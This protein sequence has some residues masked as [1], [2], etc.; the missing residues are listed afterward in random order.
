MTRPTEH[1]GASARGQFERKSLEAFAAAEEARAAHEAYHALWV[2]FTG[3]KI[4]GFTI[5]FCTTCGRE[6]TDLATC[7]HRA[8]PKGGE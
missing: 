2:A 1:E 4:A 8:T 6:E 7:P 5:E 3:C